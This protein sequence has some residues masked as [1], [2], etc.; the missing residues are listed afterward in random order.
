MFHKFENT[1]TEKAL[2]PL[3]KSLGLKVSQLIELV[4][5][6]TS[7]ALIP[8]AADKLLPADFVLMLD[9]GDS[10]GALKT[11]LTE[12]SRKWTA[13]GHV[14]KTEKVRDVEFLHVTLPSEALGPLSSGATALPEHAE[15]GL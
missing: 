6:Q 2:A 10:S 4:K 12:W 1:F 8:Q 5:G 15:V 14:T 3:E 11:N 13:D 9:S 7:A